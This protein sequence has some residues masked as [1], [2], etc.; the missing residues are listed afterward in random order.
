MITGDPCGHSIAL[1]S[2]DKA[3]AA[4]ISIAKAKVDRF[5]FIGLTERWTESICL[6]S[7]MFPRA[8]GLAYPASTLQNWRPATSKSCTQLVEEV[9]AEHGFADPVDEAIYAHAAARF[10]NDLALHPECGTVEAAFKSLQG[11]DLSAAKGN[12][13]GSLA[14][15]VAFAPTP[16]PLPP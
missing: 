10:E 3:M 4:M 6:F 2:S 13:S 7:K 16:A 1:Q 5:A 15:Q 8:S 12:A 9:M 14:E 11:V